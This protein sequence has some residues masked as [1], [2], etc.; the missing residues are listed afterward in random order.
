MILHNK[1]YVVSEKTKEDIYSITFWIFLIKGKI[2]KRF[3][4]KEIAKRMNFFWIKG[5]R[6]FIN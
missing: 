5:K 4:K 6:K 1:K 3:L 2:D